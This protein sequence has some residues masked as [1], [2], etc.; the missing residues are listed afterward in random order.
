LKAKGFPR[1]FYV[2]ILVEACLFIARETYQPI[3]TLY[4]RE[5][6]AS[7]THIG[8]IV[9]TL[10][11]STILARFILG[12]LSDKVGTGW[13]LLLGLIGQPIIF[14][15]YALAPE[16]SWFYP[17]QVLSALSVALFSPLIMSLFLRIAPPDRRGDALGRSLTAA[18]LSMLMGPLISSLLLEFLQLSYSELHPSPK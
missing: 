13:F 16:T 2:L 9:S 10:S 1:E 15:L 3:F 12:P 11:L 8:A 14:G 5:R 6:G 17:I 4:L 7:A 18:G